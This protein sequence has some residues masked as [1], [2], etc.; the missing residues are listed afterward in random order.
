MNQ[1]LLD[2][3]VTK[4]VFC[5]A[6]LGSGEAVVT[7]YIGN[8]H[9]HQVLK[10]N[11]EGKV[12]KDIYTCVRCGSITG[13]IVLKDHLYVTHN[14]GTVLQ[15]RV[16][17][18]HL[19]SVYTIPDVTLVTNRG[20]L[21]TK[22]GNIPDK[23]I[24][25]LCDFT[26][27]EVFTFKLSTKQKQVHL[28]SSHGLVRPSSV[29]YLLH[30]N[31]TFYVVCDSGRH[32]VNLYNATW[33]HVRI[34]GGYGSAAGELNYPITAIVSGENTILVSD[35]ENHRVSEFGFDGTF[36]GHLLVRSD[37]IVRPSC[38]SFSYPHLW[39]VQDQKLSRYKLYQ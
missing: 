5:A 31:M 8:N 17:D 26:K 32:K 9:T 2:L 38:M 1:P 36:M 16:S 15:T 14:N 4:T 3:N 35:R 30:D 33:Y 21:N 22:P 37:G 19:L 12:T 18:G 10:L 23:D 25:V 29:S 24:L 13:T 39:L 20:S 6:A 27:G 34:I 11:S 28:N 7:N